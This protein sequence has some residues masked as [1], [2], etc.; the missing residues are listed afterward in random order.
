M[1]TVLSMSTFCQASLP[2][3]YPPGEGTSGVLA[4]V[5][6]LRAG[7]LWYGFEAECSCAQDFRWIRE[8]SEHHVPGY[9]P[10]FQAAEMAPSNVRVAKPVCE[11]ACVVLE[12]QLLSSNGGRFRILKSSPTSEEGRVNSS[13]LQVADSHAFVMRALSLN[14]YST[15]SLQCGSDFFTRLT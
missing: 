7:Q 9:G 12:V 3:S 2:R 14:G 15:G 10:G 1:V 4:V 13:T 8:D 11:Q 6:A 5:E